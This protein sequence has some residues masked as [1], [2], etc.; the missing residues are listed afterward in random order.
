MWFLDLS[1][2]TFLTLILVFATFLLFILLYSNKKIIWV[3][4]GGLISLIPTFS[5]A[6]LFY[7]SLLI[8]KYETIIK[9]K[10]LTNKNTLGKI[11][12]YYT[13]FE[14]NLC[15]DYIKYV[16][17]KQKADEQQRLKEEIERQKTLDERKLQKE[18]IEKKYE[19]LIKEI[20]S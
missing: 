7:S 9:V 10:V 11:W 12:C 1:V 19:N 8:D 2:Y 13:E 3:I 4:C 16:L 18:K 5:F 6:I 14:G 15:K 20:E 17:D